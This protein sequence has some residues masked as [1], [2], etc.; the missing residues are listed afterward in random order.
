M[1]LFRERSLLHVKGFQTKWDSFP[2][3]VIPSKAAAQMPK[4]STAACGI[5]YLAPEH[6]E[7]HLSKRYCKPCIWGLQALKFNSDPSPSTQ[8]P[9]P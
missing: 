6:P 5:A 2:A 8:N 1:Y 9:E 3:V 7:A 4:E